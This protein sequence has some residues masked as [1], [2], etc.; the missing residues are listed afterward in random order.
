M[1]PKK[2]KSLNGKSHNKFS[3]DEIDQLINLI[4]KAKRPIIYSGGGVINS[5]PKAIEA[6]RKFV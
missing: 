3:A 2:E 1:P 4:N 5:G 6:L